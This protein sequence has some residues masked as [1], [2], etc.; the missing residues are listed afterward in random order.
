MRLLLSAFHL[1]C[2]F[3]FTCTS[4][5]VENHHSIRPRLIDAF[6][7][8]FFLKSKLNALQPN[9][10]TSPLEVLQSELKQLQLELVQQR[11][12]KCLHELHGDFNY[13]SIQFSQFSASRENNKTLAVFINRTIQDFN[14]KVKAY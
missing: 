11:N 9:G 12:G 14:N 2:L 5:T 13:S 1:T 10:D 4:S 6:L 7:R 8:N 3:L